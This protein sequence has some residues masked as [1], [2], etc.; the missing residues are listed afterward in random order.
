MRGAGTVEALSLQGVSRTF[1]HTLALAPLTLTVH[2]GT[3]STVGG[4]N[5]SGKTTLLR[6][7]AGVLAPSSGIRSI[8]GRS[9]YLPAGGGVRS[10]Q[11][12]RDAVTFAAVVSHTM[13]DVEGVLNSCDL[14]HLSNTP[15]AR[16]ST[17]QR[18]RVT[19]AVALVARPALL[20][21]DE[22]TSG[23]DADGVSVAASALA[24]LRAAGCAV[25]VASHDPQGLVGQADAQLYLDGG[26]LVAVG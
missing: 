8:S 3:V 10:W 24:A 18:A 14:L 4:P 7:A 13:P 26:R 21:L 17:G 22:P 12:P 6:V 11:T 15:A 2:A 23:L 20:C 19:L 16:L 9:L 5:G 1:G 25:L